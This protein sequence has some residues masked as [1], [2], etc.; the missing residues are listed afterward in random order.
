MQIQSKSA[1]DFAR[2]WLGK[3]QMP[4]TEESPDVINSETTTTAAVSVTADKVETAS[5]CLEVANIDGRSR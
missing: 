1:A 2:F 5:Y 4:S 3:G